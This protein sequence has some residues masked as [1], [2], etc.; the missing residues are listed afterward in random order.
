MKYK[1]FVA[2]GLA[3]AVTGCATITRGTSE[4]LVIE[5]EPPGAVAS[6]SSGHMCKTHCSIELKRKNGVLIKLEKPG[7]ETI[8][9]DI[10]SDISGAGGAALAGNVVLGGLI[11]AGVDA[12]SGAMNK[13]T[14][15]P[16]HVKLEPVGQA[17]AGTASWAPSPSL[18]VAVKPE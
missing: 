9:T 15:N 11:G 12:Y 17:V 8:D 4:V 2:T 5:T 1:M 14:P 13:L 10:H 16:L 7:Y 3:F 18:T 6:L